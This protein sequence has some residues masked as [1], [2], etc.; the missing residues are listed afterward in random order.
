MI[1]IQRH[2][3]KTFNLAKGNKIYTDMIIREVNI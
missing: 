3:Q 2:C 1:A